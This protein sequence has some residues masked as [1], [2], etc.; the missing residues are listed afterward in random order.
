MGSSAIGYTPVLGYVQTPDGTENWLLNAVTN[1]GPTTIGFIVVNSFFSYS[2]GVYY[3]QDCSFSSPNY[4]GMHAVI[5]V[6]YGSD[7][8]LGDYWI[9]RNSWNV[10]WGDQGYIKMARN[11]NNLCSLASWATYPTI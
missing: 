7:P 11:K 6:G 3:D 5:V 2:S 1:V 10:G 4:A 9:V 8:S